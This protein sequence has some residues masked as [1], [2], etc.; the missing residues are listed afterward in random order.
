L[1]QLQ[2]LWLLF[3]FSLLLFLLFVPASIV[4]ATFAVTV[5]VSVVVDIGA[6]AAP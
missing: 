6:V 5:A 4:N 3:L 2:L 1:Q